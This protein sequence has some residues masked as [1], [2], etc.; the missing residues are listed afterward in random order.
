MEPCAARTVW[1]YPVERCD[2]PR[3]LVPMSVAGVGASGVDAHLTGH[4][5]GDDVTTLRLPLSGLIYQ[6]RNDGR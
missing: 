6:R 4:V 1:E 2:H 3:P 5:S